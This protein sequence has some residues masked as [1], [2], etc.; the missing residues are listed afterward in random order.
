MEAYA[1]VYNG[2]K[3]LWFITGLLHDF[4]Y[5]K[6]PTLE[7]HPFEG[8]KILKEKGYSEE[9]IQAILGHGDHT[10]VPRTTPWF[11]CP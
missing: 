2:D 7:H 8:V 11:L 9:L 6:Y 4:D 5:E 10:G 1:S 3:D